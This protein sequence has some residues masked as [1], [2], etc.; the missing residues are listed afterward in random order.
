MFSHFKNSLGG[1][2]HILRWVPYQLTDDLRAK[3]G[4]QTK[5]LLEAIEKQQ[6]FNFCLILVGDES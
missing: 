6:K 1:Q 4:N 2:L 5:L 3:C